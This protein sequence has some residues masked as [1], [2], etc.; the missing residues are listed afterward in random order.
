MTLNNIN[1]FPGFSIHIMSC[2]ILEINYTKCFSWIR[3]KEPLYGD[4]SKAIPVTG[5]GGL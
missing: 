4:G 3:L 2:E 1:V 5:C